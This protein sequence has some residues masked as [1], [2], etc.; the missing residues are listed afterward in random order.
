MR[1]EVLPDAE[2]VAQ[3]GASFFAAEARAAVTARGRLLVAVS[4]GQT[5]WQML[6]ALAQEEVPWDRVHVVQVDECV[7][8]A[9]HPDRNLTHLMENL[10]LHASL[11][12]EQIHA[13]PVEDADLEAA[14]NQYART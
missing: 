14:A 10:L 6:R 11:R 3:R 5:P 9:G 13:V 7:A 2:A 8:P 1:I 4:G 12:L